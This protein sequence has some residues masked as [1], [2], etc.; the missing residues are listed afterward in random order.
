MKLK[1]DANE[2]L[3]LALCRYIHKFVGVIDILIPMQQLMVWHWGQ[4]QVSQK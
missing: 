2:P 1:Y 4:L 3:W